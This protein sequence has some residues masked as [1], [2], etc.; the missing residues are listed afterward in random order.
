MHGHVFHDL[1]KLNEGDV[2]H[3]GT[4]HAT[5]TYRVDRVRV[6]DDSAVEVV[7]ADRPMIA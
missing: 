7:A 3:T 2:I 5:A 4:A 6:V 1:N